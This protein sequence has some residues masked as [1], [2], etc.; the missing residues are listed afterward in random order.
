MYFKG[1]EHFFGL[2]LKNIVLNFISIG[3]IKVVSIV[4]KGYRVLF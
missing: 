3:L 1:V 4:F 2:L